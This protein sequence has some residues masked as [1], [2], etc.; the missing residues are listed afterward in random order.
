MDSV[1]SS[2]DM[3]TL[4]KTTV[5]EI[6]HTHLHSCSL[7]RLRLCSHA[8]S[9]AQSCSCS[10][11]CSRTDSRSP[12]LYSYV[13]N[14]RWGSHS[15]CSVLALGL[16]LAQCTHAQ[17]SHHGTPYKHRGCGHVAAFFPIEE[18]WKRSGY[19]SEHKVA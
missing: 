12:K 3:C 6:G 11:S 7:S 1:T 9:L 8:C 15:C 5:A 18:P 2:L 14:T 4:L 17:L 19:K 10:H 16:A 13:L